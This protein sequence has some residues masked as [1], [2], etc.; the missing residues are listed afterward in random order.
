MRTFL[1]AILAALF[2]EYLTGLAINLNLLTTRGGYLFARTMEISVF[3]ILLWPKQV[4]FQSVISEFVQIRGF[5]LS[6]IICLFIIVGAL[7]NDFMQLN[8]V[9]SGPDQTSTLN[10]I[11]IIITCI[12]SPLAEEQFFR[13][14]VYRFFRSQSPLFA[15]IVSSLLFSTFHSPGISL[16]LIPLLGGLICGLAFEKEKNLLS[17]ILIHATANTVILLSS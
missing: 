12:L 7:L 13:G 4:H 14:F 11:T 17:P 6:L 16:P 1:I 5:R 2:I 15:L 8:L 3:T 10:P 9:P